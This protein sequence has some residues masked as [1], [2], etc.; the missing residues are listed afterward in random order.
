MVLGLVGFRDRG[1]WKPGEDYRAMD[2]CQIGKSWVIAQEDHR[3]SD[4]FAADAANWLYLVDCRGLDD[5]DVKLAT[6]QREIEAAQKATADAEAATT[7]SKQQTAIAA[8][9]VEV[10][11]KV[12]GSFDSDDWLYVIS[13]AK[14]ML[15]WGIRRDGS[16]F[17]AKGIP[18]EVREWLEGLH[19]LE[20]YDSANYL[21]VI[22]DSAGNIVWGIRKDGSVY[23]PKGVPDEVAK[24]IMAMNKRLDGLVT[25]KVI[26]SDDYAYAIA[27]QKDNVMFAI[28]HK[29]RAVVNALT[30]VVMVEKFVS[31]DYL[32]A[33]TDSAGNL[34]YG[35]RRDG[36]FCVSKFELP[37]DIRQQ[38]ADVAG[39]QGYLSEEEDNEFLYKI[40]DKD[41]HIVFGV[42]ISGRI[43]A[44]K[45]IPQEVQKA[46]EEINEELGRHNDEIEYVK[47]HGKDWSGETKLHLPR[48]LVPARVEITG[49]MPTSKYVAVPGTLKYSDYLGNSFEK[50]I[51][52]NNQGNISSGFDKKNFSIDLL[53]TAGDEDNTFELQFGDW[54]PQ[55]SFH[56]K[57]YISDFWKIRSLGVYRHAEQ[58]A[59]SR[60]AFNRRPWDRIFGAS[61]Q[62]AAE[63]IAGGVGDIENEIH[64]GGMGHPDGF[65]FMLYING[66]PWGLYTWNIKKDKDNYCITKNDNDGL[67]LFFGDYMTGVFERYNNAYWSIQNYNLQ[68]VG[69][70]EKWDAAKSYKI[71]DVVYDEDTIDFEVGGKTSQVTVRRLFKLSSTN[72]SLA[73]YEY[74]EEGYPCQTVYYTDEDGEQKTRRGSRILDYTTMRPQ[75]VNWKQ[76][77]VRNPKKKIAFALAGKDEK[78]KMQYK[79][80]Y[81]DYDSP[82][83]YAQTGVYERTHEPISE[84]LFAQKDVTSQ[85]GTGEEEAFSKKEYTRSISLRKTIEQYSWVIPVIESTL[86]PQNL[87]DWGFASEADAKKAIFAEHHDLDFCI[88]FFLVYNDCYCLDYITHNTLYT[89]YDGKHLV[90]NH[91]DTDISMG[92]NSTYTNSFPSVSNSV[93]TAGHTFTQY[94]WTYYAK[95]IKARWSELRNAGVINATKFEQMVWQLVNGIGRATYAEELRLWEQPAYRKPTYWRMPCGS[96]QVLED[97]DGQKYHGY[98]EDNNVANDAY[99]EWKEGEALAVG[100]VRNYDGHYY[101]VTVAHTAAKDKRP[102]KAYTCGSPTSGGV[103]DS[104]RRVIEWFKQRLSYLDSKFEYTPSATAEILEAIQ[105]AVATDEDIHALFD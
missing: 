72:A 85:T 18:E 84:E 56:L 34:L 43:Y 70:Y 37:A 75:Y 92:M 28:D 11:S 65:P 36:T 80:E 10:F 54:M 57:A 14:G 62:S 9:A 103:Y 30:G 40:Q 104:P 94:L 55:D 83:D 13:D 68:S 78:G 2:Q 98:N 39:A 42:F 6:L 27:D 93:L 105:G 3:S 71:G 87:Q 100:D 41:G 53:N 44:P 79:L 26:D 19:T 61:L 60:P 24:A 1:A 77:E 15:L 96:I 51:L 17:Q 25:Y 31:R 5:L 63:A 86:T 47:T 32:F 33:V 20:D 4:S 21:Y 52:W 95:E 58:I 46:L 74:D 45:G 82:S 38:I 48:P 35:V 22:A 12:Y 76:L 59:K 7:Q 69:S 66:E 91:Y 67:Q 99:Q 64:G 88:D 102:D 89:M 23:E 81:Y 29:G 101:T 8:E 73:G 16:V 50:P 49:T 97:E 90:A